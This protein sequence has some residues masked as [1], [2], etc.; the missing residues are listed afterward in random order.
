MKQK[1]KKQKST[2]S[3]LV[4]ILTTKPSR[5]AIID[6]QHSL[7]RHSHRIREDYVEISVMTTAGELL[8]CLSTHS[9]PRGVVKCEIGRGDHY[10][11][12]DV[13][14]LETKNDRVVEGSVD[15]ASPGTID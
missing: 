12:F 4:N 5:F 10:K 1:I 6:V 15:T 13:N 11:E 9:Q 14:I 2:K 7:D 8:I 3:L